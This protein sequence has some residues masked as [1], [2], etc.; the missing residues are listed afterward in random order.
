MNCNNLTLFIAP[1]KEFDPQKIR[2]L[3]DFWLQNGAIY[4]SNVFKKARKMTRSAGRLLKILN[5]LWGLRVRIPLESVLVSSSGKGGCPFTRKGRCVHFFVTERC[6]F[7][8]RNSNA[9]DY[10]STWYDYP[11]FG[12]T[13][14]TAT[15]LPFSFLIRRNLIPRRYD[16]T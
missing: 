13:A 7:W 12:S 6:T 8:S 11:T 4:W 15:I 2:R 1:T 14:W 16:G 3:L 10:H 9:Y 5:L